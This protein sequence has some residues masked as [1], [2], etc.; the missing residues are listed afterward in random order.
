M[1]LSSSLLPLNSSL[2]TDAEAFLR[3]EIAPQATIIDR[4]PE[5]LRAALHQ[6]GDRNWLALRV[7]QAWGG[8]GVDDLTLRR[9]QELVARYSGALAFL[10][11][12]HQSAGSLLAQSENNAL[13]QLYLP[14]MGRGKALVGVSFAHLRREP[15]PLRAVAVAD[16]YQLDGQVP[17]VTGWGYFQ[18]FIVAAILPDGQAVYGMVPFQTTVQA[19]GGTIVCSEPMS[20]AAMTATHTVT[21]TFDQWVVPSDQIILVQSKR[22]RDHR[23]RR[24]VLHHSSF[25]LGCARAGLDILCTAYDQKQ[26]PFMRSAIAALDRELTACRDAIWSASSDEQAFDANLQLRAWAIDLAVRCAHAAV[27]ASS[28][29]AN[30]LDHPAQRVYREALMFTVSGQTTAVM[31]ATLARLTHASVPVSFVG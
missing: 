3:A 1:E 30:S 6:L 11:A 21:T 15:P 16:G 17:W 23:D 19:G 5:A 7:G 10:Q 13:K 25:A 2:L 14:L 4:D 22:D 29:A 26:H 28:G 27:V 31:A 24:N 18:A 20:L 8:M 9:F 12:Q